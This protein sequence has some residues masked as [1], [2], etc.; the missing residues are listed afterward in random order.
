[1]VI[2]PRQQ[3]MGVQASDVASDGA[4]S[5]GILVGP[6]LG[7]GGSTGGLDRRSAGGLG[8]HHLHEDPRLPQ[9][10]GKRTPQ[11]AELPDRAAGLLPSLREQGATVDHDLMPRL[12]FVMFET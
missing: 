5:I 9:G 7:R 4:G 1:M 6:F 2:D 12:S 8:G 11:S 10:G 3:G